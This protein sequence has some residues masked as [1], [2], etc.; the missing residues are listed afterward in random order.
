[1]DPARLNGKGGNIKDCPL[2]GNHLQIF[3]SV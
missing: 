2:P 1:M 3:G